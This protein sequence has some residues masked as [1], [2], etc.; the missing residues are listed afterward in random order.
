MTLHSGKFHSGKS[1]QSG[2]A[3]TEMVIA[4]TFLLVPLFLLIPWLG[5][6]IDLHQSAIQAARYEA[7]E[8][9][10][11]YE[12]ANEAPDTTITQIP[13]STM[14]EKS[15]ADLQAEARQRFF[16]REAYSSDPDERDLINEGSYVNTDANPLWK[17]HLGNSL[18][19]SPTTIDDS[20][21]ESFDDT[22]NNSTSDELKT[23]LEIDELVFTA[24]TSASSNIAN[25]IAGTFPAFVIDNLKGYA[26]TQMTISIVS[27]PGLV[28]FGTISGTY[29]VLA[30]A[31]PTTSLASLTRAAVL[32]D[33]WNAGGRFHAKDQAG[34]MTIA[35]K[36]TSLSDKFTALSDYQWITGSDHMGPNRTDTGEFADLLECGDLRLDGWGPRFSVLPSIPADDED[37]SLW[38]GYVDMGA[39]HP[40]RLHE[41]TTAY[42]VDANPIGGHNCPYNTCNFTYNIPSY[43]Y[44][45]ADP[46]EDDQLS[47]PDDCIK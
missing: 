8:Y 10:V 31:G 29:A 1:R 34:E 18:L 12:N 33:G 19:A 43:K 5:K 28:D 37:G 17:D 7:W 25:L 11:W 32:S 40:D 36:L 23:P 21:L 2:Q 27:Q 14:P 4:A 16:S 22:P 35:R 13:L 42:T 15:I 20:M 24:A 45:W 30:G 39:V 26:H 47:A 38:T 46:A 41:F 6:F 3:M 9:T 44:P